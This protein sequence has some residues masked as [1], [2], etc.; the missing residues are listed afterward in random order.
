VYYA[1]TSVEARQCQNAT[2]VVVGGGNSAG[3]A[4]MFLAERSKQV[5]LLLRG[6]DLGK[7]MSA[8]LCRRIEHHPRITVLKNSEVDDVQG[9][10]MLEAVWVRNRNTGERQQIECASLFSFI[11]T[12]P[13]TEWLPKSVALDEKGFVLTG[14]LLKSDSRWPLERIPCELETTCPGVF[15]AGDVRSGTT[16]R[17]AFAVG[18]GALAIACTHRYLNELS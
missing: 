10:D 9:D 16:K 12:K 1:A 3:Q 14:A 6:D 4:A 17:C 15:A 7:S 8:Y 18:D 5:Y 11:G 13:H 2:A